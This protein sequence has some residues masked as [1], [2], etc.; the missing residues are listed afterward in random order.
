MV[1]SGAIVE[2]PAGRH[3]EENF[4]QNNASSLLVT[5]RLPYNKLEG[6]LKRDTLLEHTL[7]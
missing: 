3:F 4:R 2:H 7:Q 6:V 1:G 5:F